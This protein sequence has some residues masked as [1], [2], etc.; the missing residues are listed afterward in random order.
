MK[1]P[2]SGKDHDRSVIRRDPNENV[3]QE[4]K[5]SRLMN[6]MAEI[7]ILPGERKHD[8]RGEQSPF[9]VVFFLI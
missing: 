4:K 8:K 7:I 6:L 5:D 3:R 9:D 1:V 2:E